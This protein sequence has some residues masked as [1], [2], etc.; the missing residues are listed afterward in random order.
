MPDFTLSL[1][2]Q[3]AQRVSKAF[4]RYWNLKDA[5]GNPRDATAAE[6]KTYLVRQLKGVVTNAERAEAEAAISAP[7]ELVVT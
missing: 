6:V 7:A 5:S 2:A 4:G 1:T 3:Q